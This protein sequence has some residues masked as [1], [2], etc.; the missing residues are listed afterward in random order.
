MSG[1]PVLLRG[2]RVV[3][4]ERGTIETADVRILGDRIVEV[5]RLSPGRDELVRD[6][7][8]LC[9]AP[10]W[11][12]THTH[13]DCAA[14]LNSENQ[15]L[16]LANLRQGVTTQV[17]GNC[18]YGAF[19]VSEPHRDDLTEHLVPALGPGTRGF[20]SMQAW[21]RA[22][23]DAPLYTNLAPLVGHGTVRASV[24]GFEDRA[25]TD[26]EV[27]RMEQLLSECLEQGAFGLSTGLIYSPG[28]FA[29]ME[30]L[31]RLARVSARHGAPYVSH[32]R[33]ETDHVQQAVQEAIEI[34]RQSAAGVHISHHKVA[35]RA[36]W[37]S[38]QKTL[39]QTSR[40]TSTPIRLAARRCRRCCH[41]GCNKAG[42]TRCWSG[43]W[44]RRFDSGS[45]ASSWSRTQ[46][47]KTS[48]QPPAGTGS[49]SPRHRPEPTPRDARWP[50]WPSRRMTLR[51]TWCAI[52]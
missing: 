2:G 8:G 51:S 19:P 18:G 34:G 5:G 1:R 27:T 37:G 6:V 45:L 12:D 32:L 7:D 22:V 14:F 23:S 50:A 36:N 49:S 42:P 47:G 15:P 44:M 46:P 41:H 39:G 25:A 52:S 26:S 31:V 9:V 29:T 24:M 21:A 10:G 3:D 17:C 13:A 48:F 35:G 33:N 30:E 16:A 43:W 38:I 4:G 28:V 11:I 40:W 20:P